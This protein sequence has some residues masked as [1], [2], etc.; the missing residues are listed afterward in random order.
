[1]AKLQNSIVLREG[2]TLTI[3]RGYTVELR[4]GRV[5]VRSKNGIAESSRGFSFGDFFYQCKN[6]KGYAQ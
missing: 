3:P 6:S 5:Y 1:M 2:D 4:D